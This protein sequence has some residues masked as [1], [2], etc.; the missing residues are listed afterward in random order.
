M[1]L[2]L[3]PQFE[4]VQ[5]DVL[6]PSKGYEITDNQ[7]VDDQK[8]FMNFYNAL[9]KKV[10]SYQDET[11]ETI[12]TLDYYLKNEV[13]ETQMEVLEKCQDVDC[14]GGFIIVDSMYALEPQK[15]A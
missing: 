6:R 1:K 11:D 10:E 14:P 15:S 12:L 9:L 8:R 7:M 5:G 13:A 2:N 4:P 3:E